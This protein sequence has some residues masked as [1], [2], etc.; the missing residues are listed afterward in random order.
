MSLLESSWI[1]VA[2]L[3]IAVVLLIDPKSSASGAGVNSVLG[4][5]ATPSSEQKFLYRVSAGLIA[6]FF[7]LT[8]ILSSLD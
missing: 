2:L 3:I 6:T 4:G 5:L 8:I 1:L 7:I